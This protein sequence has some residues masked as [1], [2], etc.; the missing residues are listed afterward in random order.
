MNEDKKES[1]EQMYAVTEKVIGA[2]EPDNPE[3]EIGK[4][5]H[6]AKWPII[7]FVIIVFLMLIIGAIITGFYFFL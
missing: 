5:E 7:L 4:P 3:S 1:L 2:D 6:K